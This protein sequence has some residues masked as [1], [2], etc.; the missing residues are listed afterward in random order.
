MHSMPAFWQLIHGCRLSQRTFLFL[1][2]THDLGFNGGA[3]A[4]LVG[5]E[6]VLGFKGFGALS[7]STPPLMTCCE[8][9]GE[10]ALEGLVCR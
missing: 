10:P 9:G 2:V 1:Q 8:G 4:P 5:G 6:V 7:P 3:L